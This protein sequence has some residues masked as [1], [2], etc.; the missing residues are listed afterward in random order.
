MRIRTP[1]RWNLAPS[2]AVTLQRDLSRQVRLTPLTKPVRTVAGA[3]MAILGAR[4]IAGVILYRVR[5][6]DAASCGLEEIERVWAAGPLT[7]P[8]IPGLLSFRE[9]PLLL[10]AFER[11]RHEPDLSLYDGQG[12]AHP[13]RFGIASHLGLLLD[14]PTIGCAKSRLIGRYAEPAAAAGSHS[15]L[16][17]DGE[18]VGAVVR[19]RANVRPLFVSPGHRVTVADAVQW[20][21]AC[22]DGYR[23]PKPTREADRY[24]AGLKRSR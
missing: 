14:R 13:R 20:T 17:D 24:V 8:Y 23:L 21:L 7:F 22:T 9:L 2:D 5:E 4:G 1:H 3:D 19:T 12:I 11:L 10:R 18:T 15:P 6:D 16:V